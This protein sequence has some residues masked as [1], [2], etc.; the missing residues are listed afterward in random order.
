[1]KSVTLIFVASVAFFLSAPAD[2]A[3]GQWEAH[4]LR[5][6][7]V[8][9]GLWRPNQTLGRYTRQ[10][11]PES[12]F[13]DGT[14]AY[15]LGRRD[16]DHAFSQTSAIGKPSHL[17]MSV[18][19]VRISSPAELASQ[20]IGRWDFSSQRRDDFPRNH[21]FGY[22]SKSVGASIALRP[23]RVQ[24][25]VSGTQKQMA[26]SMLGVQVERFAFYSNV[27]PV[28]ATGFHAKPDLGF[29]KFSAIRRSHSNARPEAAKIFDY[30]GGFINPYYPYPVD[31]PMI[32]PGPVD[33]HE[34][35]I[36]KFLY[37][38]PTVSPYL[39]LLR[40]DI[41]LF[42]TTRYHQFVVPGL[43][44]RSATLHGPALSYY[45]SNALQGSV[46]Q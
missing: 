20:T 37:T 13:A 23:K 21:L 45:E 34:G 15:V 33:F 28:R 39:S 7:S 43:V 9:D 30:Q 35:W 38:R 24:T 16:Q 26:K 22:P 18:S 42:G 14:G 46:R 8:S 29:N 5:V 27:A 1:M 2:H 40:H 25:K 31:T 44:D 41:S 32:R 6:N 36:T 4:G 12:A 11:R 19:R 17:A 10:I 3:I